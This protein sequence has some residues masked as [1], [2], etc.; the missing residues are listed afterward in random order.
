MRASKKN[1]ARALMDIGSSASF[2]SERL[3]QSLHLRRYARI[4]GIA[5]LQHS[6]GKQ[7]VAQFTISFTRAPD[8]RHNVNAFIV[9]QVTGDLPVCSISPP[10]DWKHLECLS[11]ADPMTKPEGS[12]SWPAVWTSWLTNNSK[13]RFWMG[14]SRRHGPSS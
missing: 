3:A 8:R 13:H 9:P 10:Q 4:C 11:L 6:D 12:T 14:P 1:K 7:S 5:G 2:V